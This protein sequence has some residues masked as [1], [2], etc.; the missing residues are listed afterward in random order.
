MIDDNIYEIDSAD[1]SQEEG[2]KIKSG[3]KVVVPAGTVLG[4]SGKASTNGA[5]IKEEGDRKKKGGDKDKRKSLFERY[6]KTTRTD[7]QQHNIEE[8]Q[9]HRQL[10]STFTGDK[11]VVAVKVVV[12]DGAYSNSEDYLRNKVFGSNGDSFNLKSA[13]AQCSDNQLIFNPRKSMDAIDN[14][15][16]TIELPDMRVSDGESA[17]RN[18]VTARIKQLLKIGSLRDVAN[19]WM[20]CIPS[21]AWSGKKSAY[22]FVSCCILQTLSH[23]HIFCHF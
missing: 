5:L 23:D 10:Y 13:Y 12:S 16:L 14:G 1:T 6:L 20:Y 7:E 3:A 19:Y 17:I 11:T 18:A 2:K 15:V 9:L 4:K 8:P 21:G 22:K